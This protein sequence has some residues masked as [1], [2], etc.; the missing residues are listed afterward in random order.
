MAAV[1]AF[2][3]WLRHA[4][5]VGI[6][7]AATAAGF[8]HGMRRDGRMSAPAAYVLVPF[9]CFSLGYMLPATAVAFGL[10]ALSGSTTPRGEQLPTQ[11]QAPVP[12][13]VQDTP[14][15]SRDARGCDFLGIWR[16]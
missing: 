13:P 2:Y 9:T 7:S 12:V 4:N 10:H 5:N 8:C 16:A 6:V 11:G 15:A 1:R 14:Q 3:L